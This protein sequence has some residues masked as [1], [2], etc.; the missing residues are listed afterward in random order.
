MEHDRPSIR[1][2]V[3][4]AMG[5][6]LNDMCGAMWF[7]YFV[8]FITKVLGFSNI[9]AGVMM[10]IGQFTNGFSTIIIGILSDR[11]HSFG[12][13]LGPRKTWGN[14]NTS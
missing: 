3:G 12:S 13:W 11:G 1:N 5:H 6:T 9:F 4:F 7:N 8:L 14:A 10:L 2:K